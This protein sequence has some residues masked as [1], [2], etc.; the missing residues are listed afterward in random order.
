MSDPDME[1]RFL[2]YSATPF[3]RGYWGWI[4][5]AG[6]GSLNTSPG[7]E[8][9]AESGSQVM[10][11]SE[12]LSTVADGP[13]EIYC[14]WYNPNTK[15]RFGVRIHVPLQ[16][17]DIGTAPYWYTSYD[18][19]GGENTAPNWTTSGDDPSQPFTWP[20]SIGCNIIATPTASHSNLSIEVLIQD[21]AQS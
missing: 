11:A 8:L 5:E 14:T 12:I 6:V 16:V 4:L 13:Y 1:I 3:Y 21:L 19:N 7:T 15:A 9:I 2:N 20:G 10:S 17:A 18:N